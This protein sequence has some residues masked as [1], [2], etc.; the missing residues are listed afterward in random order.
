MRTLKTSHKFKGSP[1]SIR[2]LCGLEDRSVP[3]S[4]MDIVTS[5]GVRNFNGKVK[6]GDVDCT[7]DMTIWQNG[8]WSVKADSTMAEFSLVT[9]SLLNL[10]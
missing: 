2:A 5:D 9:F 7:W 4:L 1:I 3:L 10:Y 6:N 8:F